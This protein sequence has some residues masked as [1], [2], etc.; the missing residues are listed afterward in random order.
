MMKKR[1]KEMR[2]KVNGTELYYT[3]YGS[4]RPLIMLHGNSEDHTI[5]S[6]SAEVLKERFAVY[7]PDSRCHGKSGNTAEL[8][9]Q[10]MA[11]DMAAFMEELGLRDVLFY[12]FSDGGIVGLLAAMKTDRISTLV[13]SGANITPEGVKKPLVL[14]FRLISL[15]TKDPKITLMLK[16]PHITP[17]QL[18]G[19]QAKTLVLAG[20]NDL[21]KEEETRL[22]AD[23]VPG[24]QL[25]I[26][27]G[28][29]HG[30]YIVHS[31]KLV[32]YIVYAD[33]L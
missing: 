25:R 15:F 19:I 4:G 26:L 1:E 16:E 27:P 18:A 8:H 2:I 28:E 17:E 12:G 7:L 23:S 29:G 11:D 9:Y 6:E 13:I 24:A 20:A 5:F 33:T 3:S 31:E 10:D 21:V 14:L 32:K 30:S 22:I